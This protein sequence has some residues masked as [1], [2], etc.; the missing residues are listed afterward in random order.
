MI[1]EQQAITIGIIVSF[2]RNG[3]KQKAIN[4]YNSEQF[5]ER[6]NDLF[7]A[8]QKRNGCWVK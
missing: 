1:Y 7:L 8:P 4:T 3:N 5:V 6:Y 2:V